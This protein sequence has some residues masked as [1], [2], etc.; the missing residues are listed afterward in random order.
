MEDRERVVEKLRAV[1]FDC[2]PTYF[3]RYLFLEE[4]QEY[5]H[6]LLTHH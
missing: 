1:G 3:Y 4:Y 6:I 2:D 5:F